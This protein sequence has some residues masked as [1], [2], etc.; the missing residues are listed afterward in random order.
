MCERGGGELPTKEY[1]SLVRRFYEGVLPAFLSGS[2]PPRRATL[3]G[4]LVRG[5]LGKRWWER[6]AQLGKG[7]SL[8]RGSLSGALWVLGTAAVVLG[9][10]LAGGEDGPL[11]DG[12]PDPAD[13]LGVPGLAAAL[14]A[15]ALAQGQQR[16]PGRS[17]AQGT[18][19]PPE[20]AA[21]E[22]VRGPAEEGRQT[23]AAG[24]GDE[25]APPP[26]GEQSAPATATAEAPPP[27][28]TT[29]PPGSPTAEEPPPPIAQEP[30]I[31]PTGPPTAEEPPPPIAQEPATTPPGPPTAE[32]PVVTPPSPS[33]SAFASQE[34]AQTVLERN[35][36]LSS[37]DL[38]ADADGMACDEFFFAD[39]PN[40]T[41]PP[42]TEAPAAEE[43]PPPTAE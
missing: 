6:A 19:S 15:D 43:P 3:R 33:C 14:G 34:E 1:R 5:L 7:L 42:V 13:R 12:L 9:L 25:P 24:G 27:T 41:S 37:S 17:E 31:T 35:P 2:G 23:A 20:E 30:A 8:G 40:A 11:P 28:I 26:P 4:G 16:E 22:D 39:N 36:L 10:T 32:E 38:D 21:A 18:E 29:T